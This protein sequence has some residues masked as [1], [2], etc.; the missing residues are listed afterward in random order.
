MSAFH[1]SPL[2]RI[3][4]AIV[5]TLGV[6]IPIALAQ[7]IGGDFAVQKES[8]AGG[9]NESAGGDFGALVTVGQTS[10]GLQS[11]GPFVVRGGFHLPATDTAVPISIFRDGFETL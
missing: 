11:A 2:I 6:S 10:A 1:A 8:I 3:L 4:C 9:G 5:L 7:S